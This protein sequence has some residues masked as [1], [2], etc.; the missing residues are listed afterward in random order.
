M[1]ATAT[2][3][4]SSAAPL[5]WRRFLC[6]VCGIVYD[7]ALGDPDGGLPPG[8]RFEAIP[9][10]W[11]CP[12]CGVGKAEFEPLGDAPPVPVAAAAGAVPVLPSSRVPGVV[13]VGAGRAGW[14]VVQALRE[15]GWAGPLSLVTAC[16]G[17]VYDKPQL[18][19]A[20]A[21]GIDPQALVREPAAVAAARWR[22][23]LI[24]DAVAVA[25]DPVA[26]RLRTTRGTLRWQ[27]LVLA[28]GARPALPAC[29]PPGRVWRVNDL[30]TYQRLRAALAGAPQRLAIVG[31]GLVGCELAN[32]LALAGH[33]V[34]LL[35][36]AARPLAAQVPAEVSQRLLAAWQAQGL[37]IR[38]EGGVAVAG[39]DPGVEPGVE[40][41]TGAGAAR[42]Q[43]RLADGRTLPADQVIAATGLR[44]PDRLARSAG[45]AF[46][47]SAGGIVIDSATAATSVAG[48]HALG[49]CVVEQGRA[50][51]YI[52]PITRQAAAIAAAITGRP[53]AAAE[54]SAAEA[55]LRIKTSAMPITVAITSAL[56]GRAAA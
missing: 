26:R 28:H 12:V 21:R 24:T 54:P 27:H 3:K 8:T 20:V 2:A 51:R 1:T 53:A 31:A 15:A 23:Q 29:L 36:Q 38:F 41:G 19:V 42:W 9:D 49:D 5:P 11:A 7:E 37:P 35:D 4:A 6:R 13:V 34:T 33:A 30:S 43:L 47:A 17:D 32:D 25:V 48:I 46:D 52:A 16:A 14:Q 40:P 45:L 18:S 22:V 39:I 50:S 56:G 55:V 10:D 44:A